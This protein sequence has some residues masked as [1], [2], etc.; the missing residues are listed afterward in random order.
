MFSGKMGSYKVQINMY[1]MNMFVNTN[2]IMMAAC[3]AVVALHADASRV[4]SCL[5]ASANIS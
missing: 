5:A 1:L 2:Q 4:P 3:S